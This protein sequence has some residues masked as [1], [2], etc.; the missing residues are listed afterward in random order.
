[1][2]DWIKWLSVILVVLLVGCLGW[3]IWLLVRAVRT[4]GQKKGLFW[5]E[6]LLSVAGLVVGIL[7]LTVDWQSRVCDA[8][9]GLSI[10]SPNSGAALT[11]QDNGRG[12]AQLQVFGT[13][14][15]MPED[16]QLHVYLLVHPV[17]PYAGGWWFAQP[18]RPGP[19]GWWNAIIWIGSE[20][21]PLQPGQQFE[22]V[23]V[24]APPGREQMPQ[25]VADPDSLAPIARSHTV[26]FSIAQV[27]HPT[28]TPTCTPMPTPTP[29]ETPA[30]TFTPTPTETPSPTPKPTA[31]PTPTPRAMTIADF[32][33][34]TGINN[35]GGGMGAAYDPNTANRLDVTYVQEAGRGCIARL[36]YN[37]DADG[38]SAFWLQLGGADFSSYNTLHFWIRGE[39]G[40]PAPGRIKI[41]LK[42]ANNTEQ[43]ITYFPLSLTPQGQWISIPLRDF[44]LSSLTQM[45]ELVF[46]FEAAT[47]GPSG[48]IVLDRVYARE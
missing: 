24:A 20:Q 11:L 39:E 19:D 44:K 32:D 4:N 31:T 33:S 35:L 34:C 41:E 28:P 30:P 38:W 10:T 43:R 36:Q 47:A 21:S 15:R 26:Q 18:V 17:V 22:L 5:I 7:S 23:A 8:I 48:V 6:T 16:P 9:Y 12:A 40:S 29:T 2:C 25:P 13:F 14:R 1:M 27:Q 45:S 37:L 46:T 42:R 3:L